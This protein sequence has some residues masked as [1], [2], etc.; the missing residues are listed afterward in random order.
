MKRII[1]LV[2][3]VFVL[4]LL[5]GGCSGG[6]MNSLRSKISDMGTSADKVVFTG[7]TGYSQEKLDRLNSEISLLKDEGVSLGFI[8]AD[9]D[10]GKGFSYNADWKFCSQ[11]TIK[12][13]YVASVLTEIPNAFN[14]NKYSIKQIITVSDN[15]EY[16]NFRQK[17]GDSYMIRWCEK[18][19]VPESVGEP[20]Y[21][22]NITVR[23]LAKLWTLL[24]EYIENEAP[25]SLKG[26]F[27]G[28][29]Y[30]VI[31]ETLGS[32]YPV[33]S[34]AGWENGLDEGNGELSGIPDARFTDGDPSNDET[35]TN[36]AG[37]V[38]SD[39]GKYILAVFTDI[40]TNTSKL[41]G[42][43]KAID[44]LHTSLK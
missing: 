17:Y 35:S 9:I 29:K 41:S 5:T 21:P 4:G 37:V 30:S 25:D 40:P 24:Y 8:L 10:S 6:K 33:W 15:D 11:S 18:A 38:F 28:T 27:N 12:A 31:Y 43:C 20:L 34:K 16:E 3:T 2:L 44:E 42:L 7:N 26:W 22:R 23:D 36:D 14:D 39:S 32:D 13:P 19:G 1:V